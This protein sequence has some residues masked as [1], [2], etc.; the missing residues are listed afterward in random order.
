M[1]KI[2][3]MVAFVMGYFALSI[4]AFVV[5]YIINK[6]NNGRWGYKV[7]KTVL[8]INVALLIFGLWSNKNLE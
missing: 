6:S 2:T 7:T 3:V 1:E 5:E 4:G 8:V